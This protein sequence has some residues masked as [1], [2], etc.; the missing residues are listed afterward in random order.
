MS[1]SAEDTAGASEERKAAR[2]PKFSMMPTE[3]I[4]SPPDA[5]CSHL[6]NYLDL[7]QGQVGWP[8]R[9]AQSVGDALGIQAR[10]VMTHARHLEDIGWIE[11]EPDPRTARPPYPK[12]EFRVIHN[13]ARKRVN[14]A[15]TTAAPRRAA[16]R[17]SK[18]LS[19]PSSRKSVHDATGAALIA[20]GVARSARVDSRANR[21]T[22]VPT[23]TA[24]SAPLS[25]SPRYGGGLRGGG[26][27][28]EEL[29][30][31]DW[32]SGGSDEKSRDYADCLA[33]RDA[34]WWSEEDEPPPSDNCSSCGDD[35]CS[36]PF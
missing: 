19:R 32:D 21:A 36:C 14:P 7:C 6:Y 8:A 10:T 5:T 9:G 13:P 22:Q 16:R 2:R 33:T 18:Y 12:Y 3:M 30:G 4:E 26:F 20:P 24:D 25:R 17:T 11:I 29:S 35:P 15:A 1:R 28:G 31:K 27:Q 34:A 23:S